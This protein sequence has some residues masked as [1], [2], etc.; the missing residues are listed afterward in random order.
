MADSAS[1]STN[2][3][4]DPFIRVKAEKISQL[5]DL[6]GELGLA[7][8]MI[9]GHPALKDLEIEGFQND[10][11]RLENLVRDTQDL[12]SDLRMVPASQ[13]FH[14][15]R[16]PV[17]DLTQQTGKHFDLTLV[18]EDT[19]IDKLL[20][21]QLSDPLI[22]LIR[23]AVDHGIE[24]PQEREAAGKS[25]SG[26]IQLVAEQRGKEILISVRDDGHGL[27]REAILQRARQH[28][29]IDD[30]ETPEDEEIWKLIFLPG[31]ST[32]EAVSNLSGRGVGM[33]VVQNA[34][35]SLRGK[36]LIQTEP[37]HGTCI[38]MRIPLTLAFLNAMIVR[39][40]NHLFA[41]PIDVIC[42]VFNL[43]EQQVIHSAADHSEST[44]WHD[45]IIPICRF[46][47]IFHQETDQETTTFE[48]HIIVVVDTQR[49]KYGL[50]VQEIIGQQQVVLKP[51]KG[52][53][54]NV[55]GSSGLALLSSGEV[56]IALDVD[57]LLEKED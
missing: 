2:F 6:V 35:Q 11:H 13:L 50:P 7:T 57:R 41:I 18:G 29:L 9:T 47:N 53:L 1:L 30:S 28:H 33:D 27:D 4:I 44:R 42:E 17:R 43:E 38:T 19:E 25:A 39:A 32:A 24:F 31:F 15:M 40:E 36:V 55:H 45:Q 37:G 14:R 54:K 12:V 8:A 22:H 49:G 51:M 26:E 46:Q 3:Q 21:D 10:L 20:L 5:L 56:A 48:K 34:V 16:R 52:F 23:N